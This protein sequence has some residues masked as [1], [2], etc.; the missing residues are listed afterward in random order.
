M[1]LALPLLR[2]A[3]VPETRNGEDDNASCKVSNTAWKSRREKNNEACSH[4]NREQATLLPTLVGTIIV[5]KRRRMWGSSG[6]G[7]G[8]ASSSDALIMHW[9]VVLNILF[10]LVITLSSICS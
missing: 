10:V 3:E 7:S 6:I 8:P 1:L 9:S 4:N 5:V 2:F